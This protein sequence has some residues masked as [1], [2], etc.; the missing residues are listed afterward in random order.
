MENERQVFYHQRESWRPEVCCIWNWFR[1]S[2]LALP[3][4]ELEHFDVTGYSSWMIL[5]RHDFIVAQAPCSRFSCGVQRSID[6]FLRLRTPEK[7]RK[8]QIVEAVV[9]ACWEKSCC[10]NGSFLLQW[11]F[12]VVGYNFGTIAARFLFLSKVG[13]VGH[14][15]SLLRTCQKL[16]FQKNSQKCFG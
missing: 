10:T 1:G 6:T 7:S 2:R 9:F 8:Y 3:L 15:L 4:N 16:R 11:F 13:M 5:P 12:S 14:A